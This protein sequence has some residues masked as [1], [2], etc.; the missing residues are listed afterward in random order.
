MTAKIQVRRD[1]TANWNAG[2]PPTLDVGEIGYDT[3][4]RQIKVGDDVNNWAALPWLGGTI[5]SYSSP[6][7]TDLNNSSNSAQGLFR[8]SSASA[9][10]NGPAAP[11]DMKADDGGA[12][13]L[14]LKFGSHVLQFLWTDGNGTVTP[15][16]YSRIYDADPTAAWRAWVPQNL[17]GISATEG[18]EIFAKS[19]VLKD[20]SKGLTVDGESAFAG[21]I[22][23]A[24]G[25]ASAPAIARTGDLDTGI[26][27]PAANQMVLS[28]GG[29]AAITI[30][31][32]QA[33]SFSGGV[34]V[35][36]A[37]SVDGAFTANGTTIL[38]SLGSNLNANNNKVTNLA[39]PS[40]AQDAVTKAYLE[41]G[42]NRIGITAY[43][44]FAANG[45][46]AT[47]LIGTTWTAPA[48]VFTNVGGATPTIAQIRC[49]AG[50]TWRGL[51]LT[52]GGSPLD[53]RVTDSACTRG[54]GTTAITTSNPFAF[55][56]TRTA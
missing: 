10:T 46:P 19:I 30:N 40:N 3:T 32:S 33:A 2:T 34:S 26:A 13:M 35:A 5:P 38:G 54:D 22:G 52:Q 9:L 49:P 56:L 12:S 44:T 11:I 17:W 23:V 51:F 53:V 48:T 27:F 41:Q 25:T 36:G 1:T 15:K 4:L 21:I 7:S 14:V 20:T 42:T 47:E 39:N 55:A 37:A 29:T 31:S 28:T 43:V 18:V 8:F 16:S 45:A 6:T 50:Q 24:A